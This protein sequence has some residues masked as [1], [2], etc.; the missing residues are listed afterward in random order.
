MNKVWLIIQR[1]FLNRVQKKSFLIT[2]I[3]VPLIF[4]A[5]IGGL[6]FFMVKEAESA[7][8]DVVE[9]LDETGRFQL[10]DTK[11]FTIVNVSGPIE[12]AKK[13]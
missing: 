10:E 9:V 1:E 13:A 5:I 3:L 4:P 8:P 12:V 6:V 7:K 2:T 11:R